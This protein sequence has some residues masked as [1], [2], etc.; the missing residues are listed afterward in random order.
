VTRVAHEPH[1]SLHRKLLAAAYGERY[2]A[3]RCLDEA[4]R[5]DDAVVILDGDGASQS[6]AVCPARD[7]ACPPDVLSRLLLDL[8]QIAWCGR[9]PAA[10]RVYYERHRVGDVIYGGTGGA[11]VVAEPWVHTQ[12]ERIGLRTAICDVLAGRQAVLALAGDQP[13]SVDRGRTRMENTDA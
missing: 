8:D 4:R 9:N 1:E 12:F 6:Y 7:V 3:F 13:I 11:R 10:A 5:A 2:E